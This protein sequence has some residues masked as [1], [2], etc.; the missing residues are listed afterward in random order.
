MFALE[1]GLRGGRR[2]SYWRCRRRH[3]LGVRFRRVRIRGF[4]RCDGFAPWHEAIETRFTPRSSAWR[5]LLAFRLKACPPIA[6]AGASRENAR[7]KE[8]VCDRP[9][10]ALVPRRAS[11]FVQPRPPRYMKTLK[12][13]FNAENVTTF[14]IVVLAV[15]VASQIGPMV[16]GWFNKAKSKVT[17]S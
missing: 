10:V 12:S 1:D 11:L 15:I 5:A 4:L 16:L 14:V 8:N 9:T 13:Y 3:F 17:G 2:F 6:L 7:R